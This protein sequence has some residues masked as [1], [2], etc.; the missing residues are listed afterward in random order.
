[1]A[2]MDMVTRYTA[3][4]RITTIIPI[5]AIIIIILTILITETGTGAEIHGASF[6]WQLQ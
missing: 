1:M 5:T 4:I 6:R 2:I 3:A